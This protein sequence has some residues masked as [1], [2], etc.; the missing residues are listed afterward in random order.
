MSKQHDPVYVGSDLP[1]NLQAALVAQIGVVKCRT[2]TQLV[3]Q[4]EKVEE[5]VARV[6]AD[7]KESKPGQEKSTWRTQ[8]GALQTKE[9]SSNKEYIF[10]PTRP[11]LGV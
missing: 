9:Y 1:H 3:L 2:W 5:I 10:N 8:R 6:K 11:F 4:G 7:E